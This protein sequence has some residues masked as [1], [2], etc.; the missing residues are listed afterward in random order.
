MDDAPASPQTAKGGLIQDAPAP[1]QPTPVVAQAPT[2]A[3]AQPTKAGLME[4]APAEQPPHPFN[5]EGQAD[6]VPGWKGAQDA[7]AGA[8]GTFEKSIRDPLGAAM[9]VEQ[10]FARGT[11][12]LA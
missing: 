9:N 11:S 12:T 4:D 3:P 5:I 10:S 8:Q 7:F 2:S 6:K 1:A